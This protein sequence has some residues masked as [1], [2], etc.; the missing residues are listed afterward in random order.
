MDLKS[1]LKSFGILALLLQIIIVML[2]IKTGASSLALGFS[3]LILAVLLSINENFY[4]RFFSFLNPHFYRNCAEKD[5][6]LYR[7]GRKAY[8]MNFYMLAAV[9]TFNGYRVLVLDT[10][11]G[12]LLG[13]NPFIP[14]ALVAFALLLIIVFFS[15][16]LS[17]SSDEDILWNML[18][19]IL[20]VANL[21]IV[22]FSFL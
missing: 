19:G 4:H 13:L 10:D 17:K 6:N 18:M 7:K 3:F 5:R 20:F 16:I 12:L 14:F 11:P 22:Y 1:N 9:N 2:I 21:F 8:I 15:I